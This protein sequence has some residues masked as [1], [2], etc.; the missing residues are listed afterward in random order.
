MPNDPIP[1][2]ALSRAAELVGGRERLAQTLG[3][4]TEDLE[5]WI[6]GEAPPPPAVVF[7]ALNLIERDKKSGQ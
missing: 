3:V 7:A 1:R 5:R 6:R 4:R 2:E